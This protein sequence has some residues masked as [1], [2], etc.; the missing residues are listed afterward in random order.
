[1]AY[2][3]HSARPIGF[4]ASLKGALARF[5]EAV[6]AISE[7]SS[8]MRRLRALQEMTDDQL[9]ARG[10][11]REDIVRIVFADRFYV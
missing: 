6:V 5:G 10:I 4:L 9:A 2:T 8:R 7:N 3:T 11:R 1:M